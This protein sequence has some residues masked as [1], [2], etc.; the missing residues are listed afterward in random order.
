MMFRLIHEKTR[1]GTILRRLFVL[2]G[3][4]GMSRTASALEQYCPPDGCPGGG[5]GSAPS[6]TT[7]V[8]VIRELGATCPGETVTLYMDDEDSD[9][10]DERTGWM[11]DVDEYRNTQ[12][13][14]CKVSGQGF[15]ALVGSVGDSSR[16][17]AVLR[18]GSECPNGSIGFSRYFDNDDDNNENWIS[19][20]SAP[21]V[22]SRA[23]SG[24]TLQFC[25]F[26]GSAGQPSMADFPGL[27]FD[28]GV[29]ATSNFAKARGGWNGGLGSIVTDDEDDNTNNQYPF[30]PSSATSIISDGNNTLLRMAKVSGAPAVGGYREDRVG[31]GHWLKSTV[32]V[33]RAGAVRVY[34]KVQCTNNVFGFTG[35]GFLVIVDANKNPIWITSIHERGI[36]AAGFYSSIEDRVSWS[37]ALPPSVQARAKGFALLQLETRDTEWTIGVDFSD[38]K[39]SIPLPSWETIEV[40][41]GHEQLAHKEIWNGW[42]DSVF[43]QYVL[44]GSTL[45]ERAR[46]NEHRLRIQAR[47]PSATVL[48]APAAAPGPVAVATD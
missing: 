36:N 7:D 38:G 34:T 48:W 17:Y 24:T 2:S 4:L 3:L 35:G 21:N 11:G 46:R 18:L 23:P 29:F 19:G 8:G 40:A 6:S 16:H 1:V 20:P 5:G 43:M 26:D 45:E 44:L 10:R 28:Y 13:T 31:D 32:A 14:F 33:G 47:T 39:W 42:N 25:L 37:E 41:L 12:I 30:K 15:K 9:N 22:S 27:G